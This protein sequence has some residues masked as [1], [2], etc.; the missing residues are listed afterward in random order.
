MDTLSQ[1]PFTA[2]FSKAGLAAGTTSTLT[3]G[4]TIVYANRGKMYS[5]AALTN[6]ASPT[7]DSNT[8]LPFATLLANQGVTIVVGFDTGGVV[9]AVQGTVV[10]LD[11]SGN[12]IS[13]PPYPAIP[14]PITPI[15]YIVL[16]A[17]STLV[18]TWQFGANNLSGVTGMTYL[19]QDLCNQPDR[20]QI[21]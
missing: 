9:R 18:G 7:V 20:P 19:F 3:T 11:V 6:A 12:F 1:T 16:K 21:A 13:A 8:N 14:D 5:K 10:A 15:G 4:G 17:G 2:T